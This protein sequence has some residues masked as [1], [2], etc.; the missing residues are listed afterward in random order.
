MSAQNT[1][2]WSKERG[3]IWS[4]IGSAVGFAN[5]L[6]FSAHCYRNG[7]GAFLIPY[8]IAHLIIG[9][10]ML[11][12]EGCVGQR[13]RLPMVTA[14]GEAAGS[15]GK[16]FGWLAVLTCATIGGFYIVLTGFSIAYAYFSATG[17]IGTDTGYFFSHVFLQQSSS[18]AEAGGF[19]IPILL[20]TLIVSGVAFA[21]LVRDIRSGVE[22]L[23]SFFLPLLAVLVGLFTVATFF[24]PG[25]FEGYRCYLI[26][27]FARLTSPTLWR[28]VFGQLFFSLSLG[29]GIVTG[30]ARHNP[31]SF[32]IRRAMIRVAFGDFL[33]SFVA[34]F[35]IFGCMG[36][37]S[38]QSGVPIADLV[39]SE[40]AFQIGF[41]IFPMILGQ[42]GPVVARVIGPLFFFCVF[43]AGITGVF[44]IVE[45]VAGNIEVE[46]RKSRKQAVSLAMVG[47]ACL[48][49]P[50]CMGNGQYVIDSLAPMVMGNVMLIGGIAEIL[51]FLVLSQL[52]QKEPLWRHPKGGLTLS[53]LSLR[54][55]VLPLLALSLAAALIQE[56]RYAFGLEHAV[57]W[58]WLVL[59]LTISLLLTLFH[60]V[61][62]S[63]AKSA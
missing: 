47:I 25:S 56:F 54:W 45:S 32:D 46:F 3:F 29:L 7:G 17:T 21:V 30:Y 8:I 42:F 26:P 20:C 50:F 14:I 58:T 13:L 9:L 5:L 31:S 53:N 1:G 63:E 12:L 52:F 36:F 23:C 4:L 33:I 61:Q 11:F 40:S 62:A 16:L 38:R 34:G 37:M 24:L 48:T 59:V 2:C 57:R 22:K 18:L 39:S 41:V 15:R 43:I 35:A 19:V 28:D 6:S 55:I 51:F 49:L 44:S 10:P 60:R 27:D